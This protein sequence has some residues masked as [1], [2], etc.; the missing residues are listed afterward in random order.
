MRSDVYRS[1]PVVRELFIWL[2]MNAGWQTRKK[3]DDKY[4]VDRG[5]WN[6]TIKDLQN[7]LSWKSGFRTE[8]YSRP[9]IRRGLAKLMELGTVEYMGDPSGL[10]VN[11]CN[12]DTYQGEDTTGR[13]IDD[14]QP[15]H[16]RPIEKDVKDISYNIYNNKDK[17][18]KEREEV[19]D[20]DSYSEN[21]PKTFIIL[22]IIT[23]V[24][25]NLKDPFYGLGGVS[26]WGP[27]VAIA[28]QTY[29]FESVKLACELLVELKQAGETEVYNPDT[30]FKKGIAGYI[31]RARNKTE[32][33]Q[34]VIEKQKWTGWCIEC[35]HSK[36]FDEKPS[37][38]EPC[39][40]C[41]EESFYE[42]EFI[43][44]HEKAQRNPKPKAPDKFAEVRDNEDFQKVN[45]FL[46]G[47]GGV[48]LDNNRKR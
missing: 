21:Q 48:G 30:F 12:Y 15:A 46:K 19:L 6:G 44:K 23:P 8:T 18:I 35:D 20:H 10:T 32:E 38:Y 26:K 2:L 36:T 39:D 27:I 3:K 29:G 28:I 34:K 5:Q 14:H 25:G 24:F 42:N 40:N 4:G 31:V 47:F 7:G 41:G 13:P 22:D 1:A 16:K 9:Q 37:G 33:V 11:I 17:E 45:N 43:Y